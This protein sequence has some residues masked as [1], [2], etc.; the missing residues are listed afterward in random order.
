MP[1]VLV[2]GGYLNV[3]SISSGLPDNSLPGDQPGID[4]SL[5]G[6]EGPVDPGYG[7]PVP[8]PVW[9]P[10]VPAHPIVPAPPGTPP[11]TIW[12]PVIDNSLPK[13][14]AYPDNALPGDQ[15]HPEHPITGLP[16]PHP[17]HPIA[18]GTYWML[19]YT[20]GYG[21]KYVVVD[22]S[23][24]VDASPPAPQPVPTPQ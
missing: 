20:P 21:W 19:V 22:P 5:P 17:E 13:P 23:L 1:R 6:I 8:P 12:P 14:P 9:P 11:G 24:T 16:G 7:I 2:R 10:P 4:N 18:S 3:S 15:P